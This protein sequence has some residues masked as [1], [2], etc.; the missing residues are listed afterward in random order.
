MATIKVV[1]VIERAMELS[2]DKTQVSWSKSEWLNWFNDAVLAV[3]NARPD[4][5]SKNTTF[6]ITTGSKQK[7]PDDGLSWLKV[8][9][10]FSTGKPVREIQRRQLDDQVDS[11]HNRTG[12]NVDHY[13][14]DPLDPKHIYIYPQP[15]AGHQ[16]E[17][18]YAVAPTAIEISDFD[19]DSQVLPV[20]D[21][22]LNPILDLMLYRAYS[23][24]AEYA[25]NMNRA[26]THQQAAYNALNVKTQADAGVANAN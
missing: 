20:D 19:S 3:A 14:K 22:Y 13:A 1:S 7:L 2:Q 12:A 10:N 17:V 25:G 16:L 9:R 23:K 11:W 21:V 5:L 15:T 4:A 26:M 18:I 6:N 24:D 8:I